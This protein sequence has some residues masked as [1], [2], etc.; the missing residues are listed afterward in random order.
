MTGQNTFAS[1]PLAGEVGHLSVTLG[2]D[3]R[4]KAVWE[5]FIRRFAGCRNGGFE[6]L[7]W[8]LENERQQAVHSGGAMSIGYG[9]SLAGLAD[10]MA[11]G[12]LIR[13]VRE[14][15]SL[16]PG[17]REVLAL[18]L[19]EP[20][21]RGQGHVEKWRSDLQTAGITANLALWLGWSRAMLS[22]EESENCAQILMTSGVMPILKEWLLPGT[23]IHA[24]DSMGHNWWGVCVGAAGIAC[25][26]L[27]CE[28]YS[29]A[30]RDG[31]LEWL[32]YPGNVLQHKSR[33]FGRDGG[34]IESPGYCDYALG[35]VLPFAVMRRN[36]RGDSAIIEHPALKGLPDWYLGHLYRFE[37][38]F[39]YV[40]FGDCGPKPSPAVWLLLARE[41]GRPD[42]AEA[43]L[44]CEPELRSVF[45]I[46]WLAQ[47]PAGGRPFVMPQQQ[48]RVFRDAGTAFL[49]DD[50]CGH[51][52]AVH[53]GEV[54]NHNHPDAGSFVFYSGGRDWVFDPGTVTYGRPEYNSYFRTPRAHNVILK[55][56]GGI[57]AHVVYEGTAFNGGFPV[58]FEQEDYKYLLADATGPYSGV[59]TRFYRHC[60]WLGGAGVLVIDD[61]ACE[62]P[63]QLSF[64]LHPRGNLTETGMPGVFDLHQDADARRIALFASGPLRVEQMTGQCADPANPYHPDA[65]LLK[66]PYLDF[67]LA[68]AAARAKFFCFLGF[69]GAVHAD[70]QRPKDGVFALHV[71]SEK[72]E[73]SILLNELADG[74]VMHHNSRQAWGPWSTDAFLVVF[75]RHGQ[76]TAFLHNGS[77]L[78]F[79]GKPVF[80]S[81][82]KTDAAA[83][84]LGKC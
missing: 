75:R 36:A 68:A 48:S 7:R 2:A 63:A 18:L 83:A 47:A 55:D 73:W 15:Q 40:N 23:R 32:G 51:L 74:R 8:R 77:Y 76:K 44:A 71:K 64:L 81:L 22:A 58:L 45:D 1:F 60:L 35:Y 11:A 70:L 46:L 41:L 19:S 29:T 26:V 57:P 53:C 33:T 56:G 43:C 31:I 30:A 67:K 14:E 10:A 28:S 50:S 84:D 37:T 5:T 13:Q 49:R 12:A 72:A 6:E 20:E 27:G 38:G 24:L 65:P 59:L 69:S 4:L 17:E 62:K 9:A 61:V 79:D 42:L 54:W 82:A 78:R 21:W 52:F 39:R 34:F 66:S 3:A 25:E 80:E 16:R